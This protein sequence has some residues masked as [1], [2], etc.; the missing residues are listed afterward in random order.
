MLRALGSDADSLYRRLLE[1]HPNSSDAAVVEVGVFNGQQCLQAAAAGFSPVICFEPSPANYNNSAAIIAAA[2]MPPEHKAAIELVNMA[3]SNT[4]G[5]VVEFHTGGTSGDYAGS[6]I[7]AAFQHDP[8]ADERLQTVR[9]ATTTLDEYLPS[10]LPNLATTTGSRH[11]VGAHALHAAL[12]NAAADAK[13]LY[14]VKID[15]QGFDGV[16][17]EGMKEILRHKQVTY[18][19]LELWP[20]A[21]SLP[22]RKKCEES[23]HFLAS[24]GYTLHDLA[25]PDQAW[26]YG[27]TAT[28]AELESASRVRPDDIEGLCGWLMAH[29]NEFGFWTDIL[30]VA[31]PLLGGHN[32]PVHRGANV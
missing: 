25:I 3:V 17:L 8:A 26:Q 15:T 23:L 22:G 9:V 16:V 27:T 24:N 6:S 20:K 28:K 5:V 11:H 21:M 29:S 1:V 19:L 2:P 7:D 13:E 30:A 18:I 4:A 14:I 10:R 31:D 32:C 12:D